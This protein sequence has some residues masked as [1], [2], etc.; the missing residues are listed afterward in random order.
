MSSHNNYYTNN[1][2]RQTITLHLY[3]K[4]AKMTVTDNKWGIQCQ[5]HGGIFTPHS[6]ALLS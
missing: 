5:V 2:N 1:V 6:A 3:E 4:N